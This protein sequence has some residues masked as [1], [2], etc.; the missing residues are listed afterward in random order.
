MT[1]PRTIEGAAVATRDLAPAL[2]AGVATA[3]VAFACVPSREGLALAVGFGLS[4]GLLS[5]LVTRLRHAV[6]AARGLGIPLTLAAVP[7]LLGQY[8]RL[9]AAFAAVAGRQDPLFREMALARLDRVGQEL[10]TLAGGTVLFVGT[11][12]WRVA[13]EQ[14]LRSPG[15]HTY[16]SAA[17]VRTPNYWRDG[18][19]RHS[20]ALNYELHDAGRLNVERIVIVADELWPADE[21]FPSDEILSWADE[22]HRHAIWVG[23]VRES[24][25]GGEP[26]LPSDFGIY[27]YRAVGIQELDDQARTARFRLSFEFADVEAAED[28]WRRLAVYAVSYGELLDRAASDA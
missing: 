7:R 10:E 27:G 6:Q 2:G 25:L 21:H 8:E 14:L 19:G 1:R 26:D 15:L 23:L 12:T 4:V 13:Y 3:T 24:A 9:G 18:P 22:Q 20:L 28:R 5:Y 17:W 11:E 16:R